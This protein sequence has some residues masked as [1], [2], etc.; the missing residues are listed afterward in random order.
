[1]EEERIVSCTYYELSRSY[2]DMLLPLSRRHRRAI[3]PRALQTRAA[4]VRT[5]LAVARGV[6]RV[7]DD[8]REYFLFFSSLVQRNEDSA[9]SETRNTPDPVDQTIHR[10]ISVAPFTPS[11]P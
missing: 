9:L 10:L 4:T 7:R 5:W 8:R 11:L 3:V 6:T 1:M 2:R